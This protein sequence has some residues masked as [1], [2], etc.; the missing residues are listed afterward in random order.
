MAPSARIVSSPV[1]QAGGGSGQSS[2]PII[3]KPI[4]VHDAKAAA[5]EAMA[6]PAGEKV[7]IMHT[8]KNRGKVGIQT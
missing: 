1:A 3:I 6:S 5:L 8:N 4:I 2:A 7:H